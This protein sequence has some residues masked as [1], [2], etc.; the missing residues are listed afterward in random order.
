[1]PGF[2]KMFPT[3]FE[4][5][6]TGTSYGA[7]SCNISPIQNDWAYN[8]YLLQYRSWCLLLLSKGNSLRISMTVDLLILEEKI[9]RAGENGYR[10]AA[11]SRV[12]I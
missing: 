7:G 12:G 8:Q 5:D 4:S 11:E 6:K 9:S 10:R 3:A 1:M 2:R